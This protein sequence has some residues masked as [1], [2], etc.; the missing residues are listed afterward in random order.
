MVQTVKIRGLIKKEG[1]K[2]VITSE[3]LFFVLPKVEKADEIKK[4]EE[5]Y[6]IYDSLV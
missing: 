2:K 1:Q 6:R 5:K 4:N 3:N